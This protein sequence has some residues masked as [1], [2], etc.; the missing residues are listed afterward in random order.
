MDIIPILGSR[1]V[2]LYLLLQSK[3]QDANYNEKSA[4]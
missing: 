4:L 2:A 1:I 3:Y